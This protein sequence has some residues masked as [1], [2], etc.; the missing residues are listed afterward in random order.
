M[1]LRA[2]CTRRCGGK[3]DNVPAEQV[4]RATVRL[5]VSA[6][7]V[8]EGRF[9]RAVRPDQEM[10]FPL[11]KRQV[12]LADDRQSPEGLAQTD[13]LKWPEAVICSL[14]ARRP[15]PLC[16]GPTTASLRAPAHRA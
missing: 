5:Q 7:E 2:R 13:D 14:L 9:A 11:V 6:D 4:Y 8:E 3:A 10:T 16:G 15:A 12:D 1:R